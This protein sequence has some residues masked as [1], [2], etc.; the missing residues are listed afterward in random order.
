ML[1]HESEQNIIHEVLDIYK[2]LESTIN[3]FD[4]DL[5]LSDQFKKLFK[6]IDCEDFE[7]KPM[8]HLIF[9]SAHIDNY[10]ISGSISDR[11]IDWRHFENEVAYALYLQKGG[12]RL[13][14][15]KFN[16]LLFD[17]FVF[18]K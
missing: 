3:H 4:E 17:F 10:Y 14:R 7:L 12:K 18:N 15:D 1:V 6:Q 11:D 9:Y 13:K 5:T 8:E 16:E 2:E